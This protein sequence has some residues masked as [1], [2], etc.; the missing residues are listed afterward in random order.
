MKILYESELYQEWEKTTVT[1]GGK[2][3]YLTIPIDAETFL[4]H[5]DRIKPL[6]IDDAQRNGVSFCREHGES[7]VGQMYVR[8]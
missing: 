2:M 8:I 6:V 7:L 4:T 5:P 3:F 1:E